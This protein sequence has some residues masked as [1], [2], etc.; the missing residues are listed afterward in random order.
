[1]HRSFSTSFTAAAVCAAM[2]ASTGRAN[3]QGE[4]GFLRGQGHTDAAFTYSYEKYDDFWMGTKKVHD[5]GVGVVSRQTGS[6][7]LAYGLRDDLDLFGTASLVKAQATGSGANPT[8][9]NLQDA[10]FG[11]KWRFFE[12]RAGPGTLSVLAEPGLKLPM[13]SYRDDAVTAIGDGNVDWRLR[14]IAQYTFDCGAFVAL[15]SGYDV[16]LGDPADEIPVNV[17]VGATFWKNVTI[18]PFWSYIDS[19]NGPDIGQARFPKVQEDIERAGVG[20]YVRLNPKLGISLGW[21]KT[22]DGR[23]TGDLTGWWVGLVMK[24]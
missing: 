3:A 22:L 2:F 10:T 12:K 15:E 19:R 17:C 5:P 20:A 24:F 18:T 1:V 13:T 4:T 9:T 23:N 11:A 16:R 14:G 7:Y 21:K 8:T 6:L